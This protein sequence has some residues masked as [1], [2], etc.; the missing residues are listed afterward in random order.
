MF[1]RRTTA[2]EPSSA[3]NPRSAG[4]SAA[5]LADAGWIVPKGLAPG[6]AQGDPA[7]TLVGTVGSPT[8]TAVDPSGLVVGEGWSLDWWIG[9]D[10]RWHHPAREHGVRQGV[11]DE[12]PITETL[13][14]IPG[15]DAVHRA[16]GIRSPRGTGD[17]W[18]ITEI[19]NRTPVPVGVA[20]V[21]RPFMADGIGSIGSI[22]IEPVAGGT[23]RDVAH[24]VRVDGRPAL[25]VPRRPLVLAVGNRATGDVVDTVDAGRLLDADA[26]L[27]AAEC[28]DGLATM[29]LVYPVPHTATIRVALPVG[30]V[31]DREAVGFP[32]VV[33]DSATVASGWEVHRR[34]P[35]F[36]LPDSRL[37][38]AID[39]ART[40]VLLAHDGE[41]VHRDGGRAPDL[42]PGATEVILGALDLLDRPSDVGTVVARWTER[43]IDAEPGVDALVLATVA[44]HWS[45]HR[46]DALLDWMLPE[47]AAAVERLDRADRRGRLTDPVTR[48]RA[49][50]ALA[51][52]AELLQTSG[53]AAASA[54]VV[55]LVDRL[56]SSAAP[57]AVGPD[58]ADRLVDA[59]WHIAE[60]DREG[61]EALD[62]ELVAVS[63]TGA[64][65]GPGR[66]PRRI[67]HDLA[68]AAAVIQA[69]R[70]L[71]V[72][73]RPDG[74]AL[75]PVFPDGWFGGG[76]ELHDAPTTFGRLS[77]AVRWHGM[78]PALLWELEPHEGLGPVR[79]SVPGLDP[80]WSTTEARGD[81]LLAEVA[82]P[83]GLE[84][85]REVAEHPG[86]QEHMRPEADDA[87]APP[88]ELPEGGMFS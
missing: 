51:A 59:A 36:E 42:D 80:T 49:I 11:A 61:I 34:G 63:P 23:G 82:A 67:G 6:R 12:V 58:P 41:A 74:L 1:R 69:G 19:E 33:P 71:L 48:G 75:L 38:G 37:H 35:R 85:I 8:A 77:F 26:P 27:L 13:L 24:L 7:W 4:L 2:L 78:R 30:T 32:A 83:V 43:L 18:V 9:A 16:Y 68:A 66:R 79:I 28:P 39:R 88:P 17:E 15:G 72:A 5:E 25:V 45:L 65:P 56:R 44:R 54:S 53:Q 52:A 81:A 21:I 57:L 3:E 73:E 55:A 20:L 70:A 50:R 22:T 60:G 62:R 76:V 47:V 46:I 29:A 87:P 31:D 84:L 86:V 64:W 10:D 40:Q 14:R